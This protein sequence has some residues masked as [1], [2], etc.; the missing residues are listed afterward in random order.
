MNQNNKEKIDDFFSTI[1]PWKGAYTNVG[2][3][4]FAVRRNNDLYLLQVRIF[5]NVAP[6]AIPAMRVET[7][8]II[9]GHLALSDLGLDVRQ[10]VDAIM[11]DGFVTTPH[12]K[13]IFPKSEQRDI[14]AFFD[15]FHQEGIAAGNRLPVLTIT[16]ESKHTFVDSLKF[17]W[18]L[19]SQPQP[20]D[21]VDELLM[22]LVLGG[23]RSDSVMIEVIANTTAVI[24]Q[25]ST[26]SCG[27][28]RPSITLAKNLDRNKCR[29]G[30]RA[31]LHGKVVSRGSI[32]GCNL[33]WSVQGDFH[34]GAGWVGV[35]DGAVLNCVASYD[36]HAQNQVWVADPAHSQ[37]ARRVSLE[38]SDE[39]LAIL[40]DYLFEEQNPR[41]NSRDFEFGVA[42]LMWMLGFNIAQAGA[43]ERSSDA[44]DILATSPQGN[45]MV[46][47]CTTGIL[48]AQNKLANLVD[49]TEGVRKRLAASGNGHLKLLPVIVTAKTKEEVK[50]ELEHAQQSGVVV[51]TRENLEALL[52][53]TI[54]TPNAEEIYLRGWESIQLA[55][56]FGKHLINPPF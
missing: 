13:L 46:V 43:T 35:P 24:N 45:L 44:P 3:S 22:L 47:E 39:K 50:G 27:N 19:K 5:L 42:W 55:P 25:S 54:A 51:V 16:G 34:Q 52:Q 31:F 11:N 23:K 26:V 17:D 38:A 28:A 15:P 20:F 48:K 14:S 6:S 8:N 9:A 40:R 12:E 53:Q 2:F 21:S 32:E 10:F 49:R 4:F 18:E 36:G 37:N 41:K 33:E 7:P 1:E 56:D 29:I 30:Y